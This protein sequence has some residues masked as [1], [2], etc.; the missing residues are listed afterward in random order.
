MSGEVQVC[1]DE[2]VFTLVMES[3]VLVLML[4]GV[5][6]YLGWLTSALISAVQQR[7]KGKMF[8]SA[9]VTVMVVNL[10][11]SPAKTN[12]FTTQV[13]QARSRIRSCS[14]SQD[15]NS[16]EVR[17]QARCSLAKQPFILQ[18]LHE[19]SFFLIWTDILSNR[20]Q[21]PVQRQAHMTMASNG[22]EKRTAMSPARA[23]RLAGREHARP[24]PT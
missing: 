2:S 7:A 19:V 12:L 8:S 10:T 3:G 11:C 9:I 24:K 6:G 17:Y 15:S 16:T 23:R 1:F 14:K 4:L 20:L 22:T 18:N 21:F 5:D 13:Q